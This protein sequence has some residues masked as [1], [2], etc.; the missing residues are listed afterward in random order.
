[1]CDIWVRVR[2]T[3][4][5]VARMYILS[6]CV[7]YV[8]YVYTSCVCS[9]WTTHTHIFLYNT[10]TKVTSQKSQKKENFKINNFQIENVIL[11]M[12]TQARIFL[13]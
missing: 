6:R 9:T 8:F 4:V 3:Y 2:E 5:H 13:L 1:M 7:I 12:C 11:C 10:H